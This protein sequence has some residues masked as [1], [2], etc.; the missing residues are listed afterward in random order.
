MSELLNA[1]VG[2]FKEFILSRKIFVFTFFVALACFLL[3]LLPND[4]L[5]TFRILALRDKYGELIGAIALVAFFI[6]LSGL[7]VYCFSFV[8]DFVIGVRKDKK[9]QKNEIELLKSLTPVECAYLLEYLINKTQTAYFPIGDGVVGG[10]VSKRILYNG[11]TVGR[12]SSFAFNLQPWAYELIL[13][14]PEIIQDK[15]LTKNIPQKEKRITRTI[16]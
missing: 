13:A 12:G 10:L 8:K 7:L 16:R 3:L 9:R 6:T 2:T 11:S 14:H 4:I 1:I 15:I 5:E